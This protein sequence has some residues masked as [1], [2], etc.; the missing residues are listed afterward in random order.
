MSAQE[1]SLD[2]LRPSERE[3]FGQSRNHN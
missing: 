3:P 2:A 1:D